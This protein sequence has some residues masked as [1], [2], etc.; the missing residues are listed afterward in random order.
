MKLT[1]VLGIENTYE[2]VEFLPNVTP[3]H[4]KVSARA[5]DL[6]SSTLPLLSRLTI[7]L[8]NFIGY[9]TSC[10]RA[11]PNTRTGYSYE[12]LVYTDSVDIIWAIARF[13]NLRHLTI[14][15][16]LQS[17]QIALMHPRNGWEAVRQLFD[18]VQRCKRG[19]ALVRLDVVF[20]T[21]AANIFGY[22][23]VSWHFD[24]PTVSTTMTIVCNNNTSPKGGQQTQYT[25]TCEN[26]RFGKAIE[27][28]RRAERLYGEMAWTYRLGDVQ[29]NLTQGRY[30]AL[31]R[32]IMMQSLMRLTLLP[33][34][35]V[36][37]KGKR[38]RYESSTAEFGTKGRKDSKR[39]TRFKE[40]FFWNFVSKLI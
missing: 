8:G 1:Q 19:E 6:L 33:S 28:R 31:P 4:F 26:Q 24:P 5:L 22:A 35:F 29:W 12:R 23:E 25:C 34:Y 27:H 17:D 11:F 37:E 3:H 18:L 14:H 38:L 21:N 36:F 16:M 7:N 39:R 13:Q 32:R 20:Y 9:S 10:Y 40:L 15:F 2:C 30:T